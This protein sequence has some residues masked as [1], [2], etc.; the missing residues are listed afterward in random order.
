MEN[1][2]C[3]VVQCE[4]NLDQEY[5]DAQYKANATGWDLGKIAPPIKTIIDNLKDKNCRILIPG[6]GNSY[7]A[8]YLIESGFTN[9]TVLD[10]AP[11][12]VQ[13]LTEKFAGNANIKIGI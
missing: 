8:E 13:N 7:E 4:R 9:I 10:I 2:K 5:W 3:C 6:C 12:L 1:E 11:T